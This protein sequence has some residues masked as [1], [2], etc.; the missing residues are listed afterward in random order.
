MNAVRIFL[1]L[2]ITVSSAIAVYVFQRGEEVC[3]STGQQFTLPP[4]TPDDIRFA[5][6]GDF[7]KHGDDLA[8]VADLIDGWQPDFILTVGDNNYDDG[9]AATLD[10]NVG[11][12]FGDYVDSRRFFPTL[13]NHDWRS[14][15]N[16]AYLPYFDLPGN[17]R[18]YTFTQGSVQ[19]FA[20]DSD[21]REPDG[22]GDN[23][24]QAQWLR[25]ELVASTTP[26]QV[27]YFHHPPYSSGYHG[28]TVYMRWDFAEWG[29]DAVLAGHDH[30]YERIVRD[31][32][33]PYVVNGLGGRSIRDF[34]NEIRGSQVR[35][36][37]AYGA[38]LV[39]ADEEAM[40]FYFV[41]TDD[42]LVDEFSVLPEAI[43]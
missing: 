20:I 7:G 31:D 23:S 11:Y 2:C 40:Q 27:V 14:D 10:E 1:T 19:F 21:L 33:L 25:D 36:N 15:I 37:C 22:I 5:V 28:S 17:G 43:E 16:E 6:I 18:Y 35:F 3:M 26:F 8:A 39:I 42:L 24:V 30:N 38:M 32:G 4:D 29:A 13:G 9:E 41:T 34:P 12:Y